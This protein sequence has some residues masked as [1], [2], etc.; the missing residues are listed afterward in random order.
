L[1][2]VD[3]AERYQ[4]ILE[5]VDVAERDDDWMI[6]TRSPNENMSTLDWVLIL[7]SILLISHQKKFKK[8]LE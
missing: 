3:V 6:L 2:S 4:F 1:E 8:S 7:R 5:N